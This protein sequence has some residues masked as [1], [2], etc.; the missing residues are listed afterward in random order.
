MLMALLFLPVQVPN[1]IEETKQTDRVCRVVVVALVLT[2]NNFGFRATSSSADLGIERSK[3]GLR[4]IKTYAATANRTTRR[5]TAF[6]IVVVIEVC[7]LWSTHI[8]SSSFI[9]GQHWVKRLQLM[10]CNSQQREQDYTS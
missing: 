8:K 1:V 4:K 6:I 3:R 10:T 7:P 9:G 2:K 5:L